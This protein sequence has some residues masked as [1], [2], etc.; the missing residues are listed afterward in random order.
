MNEYRK[1]VRHLDKFTKSFC[2]I[3]YGADGLPNAN[4]EFR[5]SVCPMSKEGNICAAKELRLKFDPEY[6]DFG[7]MGD[8]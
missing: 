7:S 8:L 4:L 3:D 5:C 6:K 2:R 1:A